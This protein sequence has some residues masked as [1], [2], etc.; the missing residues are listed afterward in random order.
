MNPYIPLDGDRYLDP[1]SSIIEKCDLPTLKKLY[2]NSIKFRD[3]LNNKRILCQ[4]CTYYNLE[5]GKMESFPMF[6]TYHG[7]WHQTEHNIVPFSICVKIAINTDN[8]KLFTRVG[9]FI[10]ANSM[11]KC[12]KEGKVNMINFIKNL[13]GMGKVLES[14]FGFFNVDQF[15]HRT[16]IAKCVYLAAANGHTNLASNIVSINSTY[17]KYAYCAGVLASGAKPNEILKAIRLVKKIKGSYRTMLIIA[18][19]NDNLEAVKIL[20]K[21][22]SNNYNRWFSGLRLNSCRV[23]E[24]LI[25]QCKVD[26]NIVWNSIVLNF[27][28]CNTEFS[29]NDSSSIKTLKLFNSYGFKLLIFFQLVCRYNDMKAFNWFFD[30]YKLCKDLAIV[31]LPKSFKCENPFMWELTDRKGIQC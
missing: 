4:L 18:A 11:L 8:P 13:T 20:T 14:S 23:I 6:Y 28:Y 16:T 21:G 29:N 12:Q 5:C 22:K 9:G 1:I 25:K 27:D 3:I 31:S 26:V 2:I 30:Q 19:M 10:E 7:M 17:L 15:S 24:W